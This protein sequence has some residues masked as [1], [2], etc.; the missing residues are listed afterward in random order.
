MSYGTL[1]LS[2]QEP[3]TIVNR[4]RKDKIWSERPETDFLHINDTL[5]SICLHWNHPSFILWNRA[6]CLIEYS[7]CKG[8]IPSK[9]YVDAYHNH[10]K[11]Y[12]GEIRLARPA[13]KDFGEKEPPEMRIEE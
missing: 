7:D 12:L 2:D 11:H 9:P 8:D 10:L 13:H 5:I 3:E 1:I 6:K 4:L